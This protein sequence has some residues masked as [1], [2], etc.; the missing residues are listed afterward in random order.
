M[1]RLLDLAVEVERIERMA[2]PQIQHRRQIDHYP[3]GRQL[4]SVNRPLIMGRRRS[5]FRG[6]A[7]ANSDSMGCTGSGGDRC[8]TNPPS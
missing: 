2:P 8:D 7:S 5:A 1:A 3:D 6:S 4:Q